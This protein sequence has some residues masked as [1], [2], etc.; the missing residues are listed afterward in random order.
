MNVGNRRLKAFEDA[1]EAGKLMVLADVPP[2]RVEEIETCVKKHFPQVEIEGT[3][4]KI[5]AFP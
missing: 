3:E 4:P 2:E 5:P 1:I